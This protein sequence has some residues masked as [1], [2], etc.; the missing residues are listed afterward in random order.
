LMSIYSIEIIKKEKIK[1]QMSFF[2]NLILII[3]KLIN[4]IPIENN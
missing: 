1:I 4:I 3:K 2:V